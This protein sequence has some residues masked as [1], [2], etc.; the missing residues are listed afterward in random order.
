MRQLLRFNGRPY[1]AAIEVA[2]GGAG[3]EAG[4]TY[5]R[6]RHEVEVAFRDIEKEFKETFGYVSQDIAA[7]RKAELGLNYTVAL[8]ICC[9]CDM[10]AWHKDLKDYQVFARLLPD[11]EPYQLIAKS[12][13]EALR[14]GLAHR[15]RPDTIKIGSEQWRFTIA[16]QDGPHLRVIKGEP[17]WLRLN[18]KVLSE[19]VTKQINAYEDEL[20]KSARARKN[21]QSK[22]SKCVKD[23]PP[24]QAV[25][26][27]AAWKSIL[28]D[29]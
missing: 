24:Q 22:S 8:L 5:A 17:N 19:R 1:L 29:R 18:V 7:I 11:D 6:G 3:G 20:R 16:W 25:N 21:F 10:L 4:G 9:A 23:I 15:F 13:F 28:R 12:M 2:A 26:V 14:N 27:A